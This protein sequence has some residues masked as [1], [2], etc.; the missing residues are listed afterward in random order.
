MTS[1]ELD[2][3]HKSLNRCVANEGFLERFYYLF[4]ASSPA[5]A[6]RFRNTDWLRQRRM[7]VASFHMM[8]AS[9]EKQAENGEH[10]ERIAAMHG[11]KQLDIPPYLYDAWFDCLMQAVSEYDPGYCAEVEAVW[12]KIM[13]RGIGV[14]KRHAGAA[15]PDGTQPRIPGSMDTD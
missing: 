13:K 5:V 8:M 4:M 10:L 6:A 12:R 11:P 9:E 7:L 15:A 14:M 1:E 3:F 2:L